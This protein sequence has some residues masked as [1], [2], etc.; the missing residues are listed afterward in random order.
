M[1]LLT[2]AECRDLAQVAHAGQVDKQGRDVF[3]FHLTSVA[4]LLAP[5]GPDAEA[6]GWLHDIIEDTDE[7]AESLRARGVAPHVVDAVV[8]V[9][10]IP[11][12]PY[13]DLIRRAAAHPLGRKVKLA[14]NQ[15]NIDNNAAL[16][17]IAPLQAKS[18][19]EGRYLPA[20]DILLSVAVANPASDH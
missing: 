10:R 19:L 5:L 20:R 7:T 3:L 9:T 2:L 4:E 6:A 12:E 14:D 11:G 17:A 13:F 1:H 8:S 16:A 15:I 18:L